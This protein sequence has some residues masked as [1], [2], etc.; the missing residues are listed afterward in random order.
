MNNMIDNMSDAVKVEFDYLNDLLAMTRGNWILHGLSG[1]NSLTELHKAT[2]I[3][4]FRN[5]VTF[6]FATVNPVRMLCCCH[7]NRYVHL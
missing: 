1:R 3:R 6:C 5:S 4:T 7:G 2:N